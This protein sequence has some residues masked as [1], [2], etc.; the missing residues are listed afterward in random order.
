MRFSSRL[1]DFPHFQG[2]INTKSPSQSDTLL[3][4]IHGLTGVSPHTQTGDGDNG[5][6]TRHMHT[7]GRLACAGAGAMAGSG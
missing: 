3:I 4:G 6:S 5:D 7:A 1:H 2:E